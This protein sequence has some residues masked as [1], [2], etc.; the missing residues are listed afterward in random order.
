MVEH[1]GYK[2]AQ[3][4]NN[5]VV[6]TKDGKLVLHAQCNKTKTDDELK[7]VVDLYLEIT[8]KSSSDDGGKDD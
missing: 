2:V 4:P 8:E 1:K 5:H 3:V 7:G 6:I